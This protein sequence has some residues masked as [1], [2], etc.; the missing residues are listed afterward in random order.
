M[1]KRNVMDDED[2][3]P[4]ADSLDSYDDM[5]DRSFSEVPMPK[6][7]PLTTYLATCDGAIF[8]K[9]AKE[10]V[11]PQVLFFFRL[12]S[13]VEELDEDAAAELGENYDFTMNRYA[14]QI[15]LGEARDWK[16]VMEILHTLGVDT[17]DCTIK[18]ALK[19]AKGKEAVVALK[20][21]KDYTDRDGHARRGGIEV[22]T[23]RAIEA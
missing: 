11:S 23:I 22:G 13:P 2:F 16:V 12:S 19:S 21:G 14:R 17:S 15:W 7:V 4:D 10:G 9:P 18:E 20:R 8:K 6:D 1:A 3:S 5:L